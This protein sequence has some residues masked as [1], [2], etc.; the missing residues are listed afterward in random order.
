MTSVA[1]NQPAT[2][3]ASTPKV[4]KTSQEIEAIKQIIDNL[5]KYLKNDKPD[6]E[7][8]SAT[9]IG[10][11]KIVVGNAINLLL[12]PDL[13]TIT[14]D[15][16]VKKMIQATKGILTHSNKEDTDFIFYKEKLKELTKKPPSSRKRKPTAS[17]DTATTTKQFNKQKSIKKTVA[18]T[19]EINVPTKWLKWTTQLFEPTLLIPVTPEK[20]SADIQ[21]LIEINKMSG[22][23]KA[24]ITNIRTREDLIIVRLSTQRQLTTFIK[25]MKKIDPTLTPEIPE[26]RDPMIMIHDVPIGIPTE[27]FIENIKKFN[28][29]NKNDKLVF[30]KTSKNIDPEKENVILRVS[31]AIRDEIE[32]KRGSILYLCSKLYVT[33]YFAIIQCKRCFKY[34]HTKF[35]CG[36]QTMC[37][38]CAKLHMP[39]QC[40]VRLKPELYRCPACLQPGHKAGDSSCP[41][42]IKQIKFAVALTNYEY[43]YIMLK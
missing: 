4:P 35:T 23:L 39:F 2:S 5:I 38:F 30:H 31:P 25:E 26:F 41:E 24:E 27:Q 7:K 28:N 33:D 19:E 18:A 10:Q 9:P 21:K 3:T 11:L 1:N 17:P 16:N 40:D 13:N 20:A 36:S 37:K 43:N 15:D 6:T 8:I 12:D 14:N 34:S 29:F 42:H 32:R 22:A